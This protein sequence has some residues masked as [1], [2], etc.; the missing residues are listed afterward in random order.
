M[1][2]TK[3]KALKFD[4][5]KW[6][7]DVFGNL[8]WRKSRVFADFY[9]IDRL[10][11]GGGDVE[12]LRSRRAS[13]Q[14]DFAK[15][16]SMEEIS[17]RQKSRALWLKERDRNT[18]FFHRLANAHR[19]SNHIGRIWVEGV[20]MWKEEDVHNGIV[21]FYQKLYTEPF[22]WRPKLDGLHFEAISEIDREG[23]KILFTEEEVLKALV[24]FYSI[25]AFEKSLNGTFI[26]LIPK[27]GGA[28]DIKDFLPICLVGY[29][30]KLFAKVFA[31]RLRGVMDGIISNPQNAFVRGRKILDSVLIA[32]ECVDSRLRSGVPRVFCKLDI[33][34]AYVHVNWNFPLYLLQRMGSGSKWRKWIETCLSSVKF[35]VLVNGSPVGFFGCSQGLRQVDPLSSFLFLIVMEDLSRL[36]RRAEDLDLIKGF[37]VGRDPVHQMEAVPGLKVNVTCACAG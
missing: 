5:K 23:L 15:I 1:L 21:S 12:F 34:K 35:S 17:W 24:E 19:R 28:S 29:I 27:K 6:N 9:E 8:E 7:K 3:L 37:M 13:C 2:T 11:E 18:K 32:G 33:E 4:L 22:I 20:E 30:N 14:T 31:L 16:A 36:M 25:G 26:A 10:E